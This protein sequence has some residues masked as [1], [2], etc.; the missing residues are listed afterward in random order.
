MGKVDQVIKKKLDAEKER[1]VADP[2]PKVHDGPRDN[3][4]GGQK[5]YFMEEDS[6]SQRTLSKGDSGEKG[7]NKGRGCLS[8]VGG[9]AADSRFRRDTSV[10][11]KKR[12][13]QDEMEPTRRLSASQILKEGTLSEIDEQKSGGGAIGD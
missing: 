6:V 7:G 5:I 4:I 12:R 13:G 11:G 8:L 2:V 3:F 10:F 1:G 9:S